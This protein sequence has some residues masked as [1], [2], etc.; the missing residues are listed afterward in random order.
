MHRALEMATAGGFEDRVGL[1][2]GNIHD[3][4]CQTRRFAEAERYY[5]DGLAYCDEHDITAYSNWFRDDRTITLERLGRWDE[6]LA[7]AAAVLGRVGPSPL[8]RMS[9]LTNR[10]VI[11]ARRG[12]TDTWNH[13]DEAMAVADG[14]NDTQRIVMVRLARAET[15]WLAGDQTSARHEAELAANR[16]SACDSWDR[17]AIA[18]WLRRTGSTRSLEGRLAEPYR[19]QVEGD[20]DKAAQLWSNLGCPYEAAL[21]LLDAT[22]E[23]ALRRALDIFAEL[24]APAAARIARQKMRAL[25][26]R[27][28]HSGPRSATREHP[29]GLTKREREVLDLICRGHT[30]AEIAARLFI[31]T[32]TVD[33][34]VSAVL[35][36]LGAPTRTVAAA[37]A[38]RLG[39]VGVPET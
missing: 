16:R 15:H 36:K 4:Y 26:L 13:L 18:V 6:S 1:T 22:E 2:F 27:S 37:E 24:G 3:R 5:V 28:S 32:R 17:G 35:A 20:W 23:A 21:A 9:S 11:A 30:N 34:H 39:L 12:E 7:L 31:S 10:G 14:T 25:G 29:L 19:L 33:H 8:Y 38:A